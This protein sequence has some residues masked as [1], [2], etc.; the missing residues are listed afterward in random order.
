VS[1]AQRRLMAQEPVTTFMLP[2]YDF[3]PCRCTKTS[4]PISERRPKTCP[5]KRGSPA[6]SSTPQVQLISRLTGTSVDGD[7]HPPIRRLLQLHV[8]R[9]RRHDLESKSEVQRP[10]VLR[11][12]SR[13]AGC[14]CDTEESPKERIMFHR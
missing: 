4:R 12:T 7:Q 6:V 5:E 11:A 14:V 3:K 9:V 13:G 2:D 8:G 1:K 10:N